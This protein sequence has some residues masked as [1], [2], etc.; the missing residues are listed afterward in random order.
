MTGKSFNPTKRKLVVQMLS[1]GAI[2]LFVSLGFV[3]LLPDLQ[4][5]AEP[6]ALALIGIGM[7][8]ALMGLCVGLGVAVPGI[9][10]N[11]LNV[12]DREDLADQRALLAGS[13]VS[14]LA[15]GLALILVALA[16]P[17]GPVTGNLAFG[18]LA[19]SLVMATAITCMQWRLYDELMR[20]V[21]LESTAVLAGIAFPVITLWATLAHIGKA[22]AIDPLGLIALI[23]G[24]GLIGTFVAAG[25]RGMLV[26][27]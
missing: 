27:R 18:A 2:G 8:Y 10:A 6:G 1:G 22:A 16:E 9:G 24:A 25:R 13:A 4:G 11:L 17:Q 21:S 12:A 7:I 3:W 19:S 5:P 20:D 15:L 14:C 23:A 26:P